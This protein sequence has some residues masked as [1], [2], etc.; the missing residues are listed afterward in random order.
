L[1][2]HVKT[3]GFETIAFRMQKNSLQFFHMPMLQ[4]FEFCVV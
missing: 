1:T 4:T 2:D 3:D